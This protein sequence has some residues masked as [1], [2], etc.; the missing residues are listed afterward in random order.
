[1]IVPFF[2]HFVVY[3]AL[4]HVRFHFQVMYVLLARSFQFA[5]KN[6]IFFGLVVWFGFV[7]NGLGA[8]GLQY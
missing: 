4:L 6:L 2:D 5:K 7:V 1:M 8:M 3:I